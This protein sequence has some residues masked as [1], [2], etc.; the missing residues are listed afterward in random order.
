[1]QRWIHGNNLQLL[2]QLPSRQVKQQEISQRYGESNKI[3]RII[4]EEITLATLI[5]THIAN[6]QLS[7]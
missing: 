6:T 1:M 2:F 3:I 4:L 5:N 7:H